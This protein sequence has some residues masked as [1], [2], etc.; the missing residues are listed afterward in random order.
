M[1][2][3]S[4]QPDAALPHFQKA[5]QLY[6]DSG[7]HYNAGRS[8]YNTALLFERVGRS[9]DALLYAHASLRGHEPYGAAAARDVEKARRF[10][11]RLEQ[12]R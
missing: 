11:D 6:E 2:R 12:A 7:D 1:Y 9:A 3:D 8:R 10:I 4:G 5:I